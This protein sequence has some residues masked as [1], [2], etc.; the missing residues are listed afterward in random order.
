[1]IVGPET[2]HCTSF[3][4]LLKGALRLNF[5]SGLLP[6]SHLLIAVRSCL[7]LIAVACDGSL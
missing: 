4:V 3:A 2:Q 5:A 1:M 6:F 7:M